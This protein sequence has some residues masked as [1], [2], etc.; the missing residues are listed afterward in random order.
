MNFTRNFPEF[1][2]GIWLSGDSCVSIS[3]KGSS[4]RNIWRDKASHIDRTNSGS[5]PDQVGPVEQR[6]NS[7]RDLK[8]LVIGKFGEVSQGLHDLLI[9]FGK[10]KVRKLSRIFLS[11][12][13]SP[14]FWSRTG[15]VSLFIPS[16]ANQHIYSV[17]SGTSVK[18]QS[19]LL[20]G[21]LN[22]TA[23]MRPPGMSWDATGW[24]MSGVA[25]SINGATFTHSR[26]GFPSPL[27]W[28]V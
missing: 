5:T 7:F 20:R 9:K 23:E 10:E 4:G 11:R 8:G 1:W 6:L 13:S 2:E 27:A 28:G 17:D 22:S 3:G 21:T 24:P 14:W 12:I 19:L 26:E 25:G 18:V 16:E 15:D